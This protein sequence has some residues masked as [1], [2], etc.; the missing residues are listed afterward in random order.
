MGPATSPGFGFTHAPL[1]LAKTINH[2]ALQGPAIQED[3]DYPRRRG[4]KL[5]S[6][7]SEQSPLLQGANLFDSHRLNSC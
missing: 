5:S 1:G 4:L 2:A 6:V 3:T 7:D